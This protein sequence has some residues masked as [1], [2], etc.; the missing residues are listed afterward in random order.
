MSLRSNTLFAVLLAVV[1]P[2]L[3][4]QPISVG[5]GSYASF[6]PLNK[7]TTSTE[8]RSCIAYQMEH[9][10][11]YITDAMAGKPIPSNDWWTRM[12]VEPYSGE[13][14]AYPQMVKAVNTGVI[15]AYPTFWEATGHEMKT[16][17]ELQITANRFDPSDASANGWHDWGLDFVMADASNRNKQMRVTI[18]HGVPFTWVECS[19][20]S[21]I[22]TP[23]NT[24]SG[25]NSFAILTADNQSLSASFVS[26]AFALRVGNDLYGIYAPE[27]TQW[28]I[29]DGTL[30]ASF[31]GDATYLSIAVLTQ[32]SDLTV[33]QPY[34]HSIIRDTRVDWQYDA[35]AGKVRTTWSATVENM[36]GG[37][38]TNILQGFIP[39]HYKNNTYSMTF[40]SQ[41]YATPRGRMRMAAGNHFTI[42]YD[43]HGFTPYYALPTDS[44]GAHAYDKNRMRMMV[45]EYAA[46]GGFGTDT[47]WGGKGL[48]QMALYMTMAYEMGEMALFEQCK[49]RLK[50]ALVNWYTY[51]PGEN[52][53]YFARYN[54]W[55]AMIGFNTSYDSD[56]FNDHHFHYGYFVYAS[57]LLALFDD[58]FRENYGQMARMVARDY[59]NWQHDA[60]DFPL[61]RTLDPWAGHSY[62]GGLGDGGGNGQES[63][64]EA[65]QGWGGVLLLGVALG[66]DE[67]RDA[68]IFG[69]TLEARGTAEY[70]FDRDRE[71]IDYTK[72]T[73][74]WSSNLTSKGVGWWTWF[75]G[76]PVWMHGIQWMPI[77][78]IL[79]YLSEDLD[80]A[81]W[82][83]TQMWQTK[84]MGDWFANAGLGH[85]SGIGNVVLSYLQRF[86]ADS[87][88]SVFDQLWD[89]NYQL[90]K[91]PDTGGISYFATHS[92]RSYGDRQFDI[93]ASLPMASAYR[94][95]EDYT[96][97]VY[98]PTDSEQSVTFYRGNNQL[99]TFRAPAHRFTVYQD[100]P[101]ASEIVLTTPARTVTPGSSLQLSATVLDQYGATVS[102]PVT[103]HTTAGSISATG[104]YSA[105][106]T[107]TTALITVQS[108][109]L[110][111]Q[112]SLRVDASPVLTRVEWSPDYH[113]FVV[114]TD[115]DFSVKAYDQYDDLMD[116]PVSWQMTCNGVTVNNTPTLSNAAIG[117][118]VLTAQIEGAAAQTNTFYVLPQFQNIAL[119]C[120]ATESSHENAGSLAQYATDGNLSTRWGSQ[121]RDNEWIVVNLQT[122]SYIDHISIRW[123]A[124][125]AAHYTFELSDDGIH[126]TPC[127]DVF[128]SGGY[129]TT[130]IH[131]DG[132]YIRLKGI[133]RGSVYGISLYEFEVYGLH[134]NVNPSALLGL[135]ITPKTEAVNV[136]EPLQLYAV[137]YNAMAQP[138]VVQPVWTIVSGAENATI[139]SAGLLT[140]THY[141]GVTVQ[142]S[143]N[144]LSAQHTIYVNDIERLAQVA[145]SPKQIT[146]F[147]GATHDFTTSTMSQ[148]SMP[149]TDIACTVMAQG[150]GVQVVDNKIHALMT[151][152]YF[153]IAKAS[154]SLTT[155]SDTML[156]RVVALSEVNLA[157]HKPV[158]ASSYENE[159]TL[160][161]YI[162]DDD[163]TTRWGSSFH[164]GE[165]I[166]IDLQDAFVLSSS[167][168][169]WESAY[170]SAY[171]IDASVDNENWTTIYSTTNSTGHTQDITLPMIA[172]RY[173][174]LTC[175]RRATGYGASLYEWELYGTAIYGGE[176]EIRFSI[177]TDGDR[178]VYGPDEPIQIVASPVTNQFGQVLVPNP[179]VIF[180]PR[181]SEGNIFEAVHSGFYTVRGETYYD[182]QQLIDSVSFFVAGDDDE[183][184]ALYKTIILSPNANEND[185]AKLLNGNE[186]INEEWSSPSIQNQE[187]DLVVDLHNKYDILYVA[188]VFDRACSKRY[189]LYF[190]EDNLHWTDP[191]CEHTYHNFDNSE[192]L[193]H[194]D[195]YLDNYVHSGVRY[196]KMH[197]YE[198]NSGY[199]V[200]M[201]EIKA[202]GRLTHS[203]DSVNTSLEKVETT[204]LDSNTKQGIYTITGQQIDRIMH[205]G[206]YI[207]NGQKVIVQPRQ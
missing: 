38:N 39:H 178:S 73:S 54:R 58:D 17:S 164:D 194:T 153:V 166:K 148:F 119:G 11:L 185:N 57:A 65:M 71:N 64:S 106:Q 90:A 34:A 184:I 132:Q 51:T 149:L 86:D 204:P 110:S 120:P 47:Y 92:H 85:E 137:G 169:I 25:G 16:S 152:N 94:K 74:P 117:Q 155:I 104:L 122:R 139:N 162:N 91:N 12:L 190:S 198:G 135:D 8:N 158:T 160:P 121:H 63:T 52:D 103:W 41:E 176:Q 173:V 197:S 87:A 108:G 129:V 76:D 140:T 157:S 138:Q 199:G 154:N 79:D 146:T 81:R 45:A 14:W 33:Y 75:S 19:Q 187:F 2:V 27:G 168:L 171:H 203:S 147:V 18:A 97:T 181:L 46:K 177:S 49:S 96:Y 67:M 179:Q 69:Y 161:T 136:G 141:G 115:V 142:A 98:N 191:L 13:M 82:D 40:M 105:P 100:A 9:R 23:V 159:S 192:H 72:Y 123:E 1:M 5:K 43:Y 78:P 206:L 207:V 4:Q 37:S 93:H 55:G 102:T 200:K 114:G 131:R 32:L 56:T 182:N 42:T 170:A 183:N 196:I 145:I 20:L 3:A 112:C 163:A 195:Y 26:S 36:D 126:F 31:A 143:V 80:Y 53:M 128:C 113:H 144:G 130:P 188:L 124:A 6:A 189:T 111:S 186:S 174:R 83:Y 60:D 150:S 28:N 193:P 89:G 101:V 61:F 10:Q 133:E 29:N 109:M 107:A 77:S 125:Y 7:S 66:D 205:P 95:G 21:P 172:A 50:N 22:I 35:I 30:Q 48:T 167:R 68:G 84:Q 175:D 134:N 99:V 201:R 44:I 118:Y 62:A 180:T 151:G 127:A 24:L 165:W 116:V 70:W 202:Y 15:V 156:V 59:A 88:A